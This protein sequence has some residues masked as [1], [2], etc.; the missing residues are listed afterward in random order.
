M[1]FTD[2]YS[3]TILA[4]ALAGFLLL[5]QLI[6]ADLAAIKTG[7]KPGHPIPADSNT[8]LFRSARAH[9][10]TNESISVF[11]LFAAAGVLANANPAWLNTLS[12]AYVGCRAGHMT[13]YY[14]GL[15]LPRSIVF[16]ASLI[17]L[18]GMFMTVLCGFSNG[19]AA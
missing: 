15:M 7:H 2:L 8:F 13:A 9:A 3:P 14:A 19:A 12:W 1:H 11:L 16:G 5:L 17:V 10:N 18:L 6:V 4:M